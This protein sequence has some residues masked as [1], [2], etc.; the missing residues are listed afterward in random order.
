MNRFADLVS[1]AARDMAGYFPPANPTSADHPR[2]I[3]LD[4]NENPFGPSPLAIEA[5]RRALVSASFYPDNDCTELRRKLASHHDVHIQQV[6]VTAGSTEMLSLL[7]Q[8]MLASGLNAI[9]SERSFIV[10]A[11][12]VRATGANF[13][14]VPMSPHADVFDLDAILAAIN[15]ATRLVF[16]T[17]PNNP[18]GTVLGAAAID[19]FL[20]DV[21]KHVVV[22]LDE[23]YFD[24][25]E[26]FAAQRKLEYSHSLESVR[27]GGNLIVLRTFSKAHGLAGLRVGYGLG[28]PGLLDY[29]RS[30]QE[31]FSVSSVAQAAAMAALDDHAHIAQAVSNN[32]AQAHALY[33]ELAGLGYHVVP[34]FANFLYCDVKQPAA[35][36]SGRLLR[37]G[38]AVRP[39][40]AWGAPNCIRV[41][42]GTPEQNQALLHAIRKQGAGP[43]ANQSAIRNPP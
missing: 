25:A 37:E 26:H 28:P 3:K 41:T 17:N 27:R 20:A 5:M 31:A 40:T 16:L 13:I 21:P 23:A 15:P 18:T 32:A 35:E 42:I 33:D 14:Q 39:L 24:F 22:V 9:T 12:A 2:L 1:K 30:M 29:C 38:I 7:C 34:T 11:M 6:L 36:V 10:Y 43:Q 4:S 8:T 19:R